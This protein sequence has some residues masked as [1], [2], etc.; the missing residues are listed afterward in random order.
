MR[1]G[2]HSLPARGAAR[3]GKYYAAYHAKKPTKNDF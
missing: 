3:N 2:E 1:H